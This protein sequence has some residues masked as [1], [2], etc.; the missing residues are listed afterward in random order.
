MAHKS[1]NASP[2]WAVEDVEAGVEAPNYSGPLAVVPV[3]SDCSTC[4]D[5]DGVIRGVVDDAGGLETGSGNTSSCYGS[6][7][8]QNPDQAVL[9]NAEKEG[10][11]R[12][13]AKQGDRRR[14]CCAPRTCPRCACCCGT[15]CT[16]LIALVVAAA[17]YLTPKQP[18]WELTNLKLDVIRIPGLF[19]QGIA[20]ADT[21]DCPSYD[22]CGILAGN[23][24]STCPHE[25]DYNQGCICTV[26]NPDTMAAPGSIILADTT[27]CPIL[28]KCG[29]FG[30]NRG[31]SVCPDATWINDGCTCRQPLSTEEFFS[32]LNDFIHLISG[33]EEYPVEIKLQAD[34][35]VHN[36]NNLG[37]DTEE[38]SVALLWKGI[39]FGESTVPSLHVEPRSKQVIHVEVDVNQLTPGTGLRL[40]ADALQNQGLLTVQAKGTIYAKGPFGI[41]VQTG[42]SCEV[43]TDLFDSSN[44]VDQQCE[45]TY[46]I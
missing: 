25:Y 42:V 14:C 39:E 37:A 10:S 32:G 8:E 6:A 13:L 30:V 40:L 21:S 41:K 22:P 38:G 5:T 46:D 34:V 4:D 44:I 9:E 33:Q 11:V 2:D 45:Y 36:P 20:V 18:Q 19:T 15:C 26:A 12:S 35:E 23:G 3:G 16:L 17:L 31:C 1:D 27:A 28:D 29:F 43:T 24:C 7:D